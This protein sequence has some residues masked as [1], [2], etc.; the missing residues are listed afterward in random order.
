MLCL[1]LGGIKWASDVVYCRW[2]YIRLNWCSIFHF[3]HWFER[4]CRTFDASDLPRF[5]IFFLIAEVKRLVVFYNQFYSLP[6]KE[7]V[8]E[9][10]FKQQVTKQTRVDALSNTEHLLNY[11]DRFLNSFVYFTRLLDVF[12]CSNGLTLYRGVTYQ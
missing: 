8:V 1:K 2:L 9:N 12:K 3:R 4:V 10:A 6:L 5:L 11:C 7:I